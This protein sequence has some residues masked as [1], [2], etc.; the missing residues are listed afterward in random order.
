MKELSLLFD[1]VDLL[2]TFEQN[3][4]NWHKLELKLHSIYSDPSLTLDPPLQHMRECYPVELQTN[5]DQTIKELKKYYK[6]R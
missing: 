4:I 1:S 2:K 5:I 6:T 3:N